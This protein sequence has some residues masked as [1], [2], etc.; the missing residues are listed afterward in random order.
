[1]AT[2]DFNS[3]DDEAVSIERGRLY[4]AA[5]NGDWKSIKDIQKIQRK[6]TK[7]GETTLHIA[8]AANQEEFVRNLLKT[9]IKDNLIAENTVGNTALTYAAA[10]GNVNIAMAMLEK[11]HQLPNLGSG[12]KPLYM[13][14]SLG[15]GQMT[16]YLYSQTKERVREWDDKEQAKLFIACVKSGLYG[17]ALQM[18]EDNSNLAAAGN[19]D[20]ETALH[21]LAHDPSAFVSEIRPWLK[22]KQENSKQSQANELFEICLQA[23]GDDV[24][25]L[26]ETSVISHVLFDAVE[27]GNTEFLVK[28]IRFDFDL[29]WKTRNSKSIF[30]IAV[31]KRHESIFNILNEIGSIGDLIIDRIEEDGSN[32]L[33]LAAGLAPQEKLNAISGAALQMQQEI[34]WFKEV[35][36]VVSPT[37]KEMKNNKGDTPYILFAKNHEELRKEGEKW[38]RSTAEYSMVVAILIGLIMFPRE[39]ADGL[40]D[41]P[42]LVRVFS[43]SSAIALFCSSTSLVMFLSIL[44]SRYSYNDFLV[45]LP[46]RLMIGV[47][48]LFISIAAMMVAFSASFWSDNHNHQELPLILVVIGLFACVPIICVLLKYRLFVDIVRSTFFRFRKHR[49]LL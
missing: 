28:L 46:V 31:E 41:S 6:I 49:R 20:G 8:A 5:L 43:V 25:N 37:F 26:N 35:E 11:N 22:L 18:L 33:H 12:I 21:V 3:N 2:K 44:T 27:V 14:A 13:A 38:M 34:L 29:L 10:T 4:R 24:E 30:H 19:S 9:M 17:V 1:M 48:S 40:K 23:Y 15:H 47:A 16:N 45:W 42:N 36:K 7:K 32:I 39:K